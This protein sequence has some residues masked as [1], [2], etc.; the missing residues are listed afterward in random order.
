MGVVVLD[1]FCLNVKFTGKDIFDNF[2]INWDFA[3]GV[4]AIA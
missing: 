2:G 4:P 1:N 3:V